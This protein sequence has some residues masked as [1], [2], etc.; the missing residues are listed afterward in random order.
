MPSSYA[1]T[2]KRTD[3]AAAARPAMRFQMAGTLPVADFLQPLEHDYS[4][5]GRRAATL[6]AA[7]RFGPPDQEN[8]G[9]AVPQ[10]PVSDSC[11]RDHPVANPA[12]RLPAI[13]APHDAWSRFG[14]NPE[15]F[16][17]VMASPQLAQFAS[18][19]ESTSHSSGDSL[20]VAQLRRP[21]LAEPHFVQPV[22]CGNCRNEN[23]QRQK[24]GGSWLIFQNAA[25]KVEISIVSFT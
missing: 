4:S 22:K 23:G 17:T 13:D 18:K 12:R 14:C 2:G 8:D 16:A 10:P 7:K 21:P 11:G 3:P 6:T 19:L 9:Q 25:N 1:P 24:H 5:K 20:L 15:V